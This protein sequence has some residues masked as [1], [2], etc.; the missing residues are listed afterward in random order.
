MEIRKKYQLQ[1]RK[2]K[3]PLLLLLLCIIHI[4]IGIFAIAIFYF[5]DNRN[6]MLTSGFAEFLILIAYI[7]MYYYLNK[8]RML[9]NEMTRYIESLIE[10]ERSKSVFLEN[11]QGMAYRCNYD[12]DWTMKYVSAGCFEL[13]GYE[14]DSLIDNKVLPFNDLISPQY[15]DFLWEKWKTIVSEKSKLREEYELITASGQIKW[16]YEQGQAI[17]SEKGE[18]IALEG[19]VIDISDRKEKEDRLKYLSEH[20]ILSGLYNR[21][22]FENQFKLE[23]LTAGNH[24]RA[25]LMVNIRNFKAINTAY[26]F[27]EGEKVIKELGNKLLEFCHKNCNLF[28]IAIDRFVFDFSN[29]SSQWD[30]DTL[31]EKIICNINSMQNVYNLQ[32]NIGIV[33]L[34]KDM[35][36]LNDILKL[37]TIAAEEASKKEELHYCYFT[38]GML[39]QIDRIEIIKR[40]LKSVVEGQDNSTLFMVYQ[41]IVQ[42]TT[43]TIIA[44]EALARFHS[45]TLGT[46]SPIEFIKI[47]E[48]TELIV[49][50]GIIIIRQSLK[51]LNELSQKGYENIS[52]S[53]NISVIQLMREDF[54]PIFNSLIKKAQVNPT[55]VKIELTES[56]FSNHFK[57]INTVFD[58]LKR[59]GVQIALDDFGTGY[60]SLSRERELNFDY[61]K[62]DKFFIDRLLL[63]DKEAEITGDIISMAHK[64]GHYV[65]AEGV[66]YEEQ[67][68]Y[69]IDHHCDFIQGYLFSKPLTGEI[70]L[71]L[72]EN[73]PDKQ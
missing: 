40:D 23:C 73:L 19:L 72:L 70:A 1:S 3:I 57:Q 45:N 14:P 54:I 13:T 62:I 60:S 64:L 8:N 6:G 25:I 49:P 41:P 7:I 56:V 46:V 5:E 67:R 33:E 12:K 38:K 58:K 29:Y 44:F 43:G 68:Q 59:L 42:A 24:T 21:R 10:N 37:A 9:H 2:D 65:I 32:S 27:D 22:Y 39:D 17:Y 20:D 4:L 48:D 61:M 18:V 71:E 28:H 16:V 34:N 63:E 31:C 30:I 35:K 11:L 51:F 15:Q 53:I 55:K 47:A 69:L 50:L 52:I 26:G 66:E 36:D